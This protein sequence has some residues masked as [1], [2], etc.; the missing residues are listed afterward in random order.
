[1]IPKKRLTS[2]EPVN[3]AKYIGGIKVDNIFAFN[4]YRPI[5]RSAQDALRMCC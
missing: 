3:L 4:N 2:N 1:L 5:L